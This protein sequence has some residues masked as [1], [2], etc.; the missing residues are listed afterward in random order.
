MYHGANGKRFNNKK[1]I[2]ENSRKSLCNCVGKSCTLTWKMMCPTERKIEKKA[3][4]L[5]VI[6]TGMEVKRGKRIGM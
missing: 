4:I 1:G 5:G 6:R 2:K 3:I